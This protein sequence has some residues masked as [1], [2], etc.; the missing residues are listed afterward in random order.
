MFTKTV[1]IVTVLSF[2]LINGKDNSDKETNKFKEYSVEVY[3]GQELQSDLGSK[4]WV[5]LKIDNSFPYSSGFDIQ[6]QNPNVEIL[7]SLS[8]AS[9]SLY[10][11]EPVVN[12]HIKVTKEDSEF[13][14]VKIVMG[15]IRDDDITILLSK[16]FKAK[17]WSS[18]NPPP[19]KKKEL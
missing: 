12:A 19:S 16:H 14:G 13:Q 3:V 18:I 4:T 10:F 11:K 5:N 6:G 15:G 2:L 8:D 7:H 17:V 1:S 9:L